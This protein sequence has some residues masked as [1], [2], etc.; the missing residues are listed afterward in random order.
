[1]EK[2]KI[3]GAGSIGNHLANACRICDMQVDLVDN[4]PAALLR[5]R[6][7]IYPQ[8][9]GIWDH[10]INLY[11]SSEQPKS[12][13]DII[14]V[15][16]PPDT[17]LKVA[18]EAVKELPKLI[19]I[20]KPLCDLNFEELEPLIH[21]AKSNNIRLLVGYDH[22]VSKSFQYFEESIQHDKNIMTLDVEFREYWGGIFAAH[23]WLDGPKDSYLGFYKR[24][25]G[26]LAEHSHGLHLYVYLCA[27]LDLGE[28][29]EVTANIDYEINDDVQFDRISLINLKTDKGLIGRCV[30]DVVTSN[31]NKTVNVTSRDGSYVLNFKKEVDSVSLPSGQIIHFDK[32]RPDDFITEIR[33]IQKVFE[34]DLPSPLDIKHGVKVMQI[35]K[36]AHLSAGEEQ[37]KRL[38]KSGDRL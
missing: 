18:L 22:A 7:E 32:T 36:A 16:T 5:T 6:E 38:N 3:I 11:L 9:Y 25:G 12:G 29:T 37:T 33:H 1:L 21:A 24:G 34:E 27:A 28:I 13:Y 35:I 20:E 14:F 23:P 8:R 26:A 30:Q 17:H 15:G 19:V 31:V 4:D 10:K 2:V